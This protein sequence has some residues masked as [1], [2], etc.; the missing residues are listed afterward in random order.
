MFIKRYIYEKRSPVIAIPKCGTRFLCDSEYIDTNEINIVPGYEDMYEPITIDSTLIWRNPK[1]HLISAIQTD[2]VWGNI[3]KKWP[4]GETKESEWDLNIVIQNLIDDYSDHW[5]PNLYKNLY[6]IWNKTPFKLVELSE[7]SNLFGNTIPYH[8]DK[9][10]SH[11]ME[12]YISK[13]DILKLIP[14]DKLAIMYDMCDTDQLWLNRMLN[15][16]RGLVSYDKYLSCQREI[17]ELRK[18]IE[19]LKGEG[20]SKL[21]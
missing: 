4:F 6:T 20:K 12:H 7:L 18:D 1:K 8:V 2:Y 19:T 11:D 16:E 15:G 17:I 5:S 10:N 14:K 3:T 9:Y 21:I 13:E